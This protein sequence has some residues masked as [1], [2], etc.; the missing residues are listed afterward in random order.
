MNV[1]P[2]SSTDFVLIIL[3]TM[4]SKSE[5]SSLEDILDKHLPEPELAEVKRILYG[6][7]LE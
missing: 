3:K 2:T 7:Q 6:R 5:I 4:A 1:F